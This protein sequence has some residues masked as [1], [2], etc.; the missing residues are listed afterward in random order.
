M[1]ADYCRG[2]G[3]VLQTHDPGEP[4]YIPETVLLQKKQTIC[5]RCFQIT[6]YGKAGTIQPSSEQIRQSI[7][8]A[9]NLSELII[10]VVDFLD[11]TGTVSVW[12]DV[13]P[14]KP[15]ILVINKI[16]LLPGRT[17]LE[18]VIEYVQNYV[19][20]HGLN[21]PR[22][23]IPLSSLKGYGID[24]L[25][26]RIEALTPRGTRVALFGATNVGKSSLIKR[27]LTAERSSGTPTISKF[28][29]TTL[30]LSNWSILRGRNTL[31]DTPGLNPGDR[32]GDLV[33]PT[34]GS[35]L[36]TTQM[37]RKLWGLKPGKGLIMG[38]LFG[39]E[40]RSEG[41][42]V[43]LAF[44]PG[45]MVFHRTDQAKVTELLESQPDWLGMV[46]KGCSGK[47]R[48]MQTEVELAPGRDIAVA[49]LG[50]ISLRGEPAKFGLT[51]P[52]GIRWEIR[53]ALIGKK[54]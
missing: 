33:C 14:D 41:E 36:A 52:E 39:V 54:E 29:G 42:R 6:H 1:S 30:G 18:E 49:G 43:V 13:L 44:A 48:W 4:G 19:R 22:E 21:P 40:N 32:L 38:G 23:I 15:Y 24:K 5:Q 27:M 20:D 31:I 51:L 53:P 47:L 2:C 9:A 50:W 17:L 34:C 10:L 26:R 11:L 46:C 37:E 28:P 3:S 7:R 45:G 8:K 12:K 25:S 16:D 35:K